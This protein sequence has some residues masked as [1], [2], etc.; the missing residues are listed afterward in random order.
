MKRQQEKLQEIKSSAHSRPRPELPKVSQMRAVRRDL[1]YIEP[2]RQR[3]VE[4]PSLRVPNT[5]QHQTPVNSCKKQPVRLQTE[6]QIFD[7]FA[8][9]GSHA[10]PSGA[11]PSLENMSIDDRSM[12]SLEYQACSQLVVREQ[13]LEHEATHAEETKSDHYVEQ[14]EPEPAP[15]TRFKPEESHSPRLAE[16]AELEEGRDGLQLQVRPPEVAR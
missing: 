13:S 2:Y 14:V 16:K 9:D 10:V 8:F 11:Q 1:K 6:E 3:S 12:E 15:E 7:S 5:S 4:P